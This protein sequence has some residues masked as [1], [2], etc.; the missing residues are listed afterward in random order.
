VYTSHVSYQAFL[1]D[2]SEQNQLGL[3]LN[4]LCLLFQRPAKLYQVILGAAE[5]TKQHRHTT[6]PLHTAAL[7]STLGSRC[8]VDSIQQPIFF[9]LKLI[10]SKQEALF[11][12]L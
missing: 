9:S 1:G 8:H 7:F 2:F 4:T 12:F 11:N 5:L 6:L 3:Q 10:D